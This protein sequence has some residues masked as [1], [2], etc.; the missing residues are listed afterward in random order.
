V[1][2]RTSVEAAVL[3]GLL[4]LPAPL[5]RRLVGPPLV[6]DGQT[7]SL[8]TQA[9]LWSQRLARLPGAETLPLPEGRRALLHQTEVVRGRQPIGE[10]R[11][12]T[13]AGMPARHYLPSSTVPGPGPMV[14][15]FHGG[16]FIFGDLDSHDAPCRV[17]AEQ[18]GVPVLAVDYGL[19]P[20]NP[21]PGPFD[22][23]ET[24]YR[25]ALDHAADLDL[26]PARL[27]VGGDSAG[28]NLAAWT[29]VVAARSRLPLAW[30]LLI[31]PVTQTTHDTLSYRLFNKD[32]FLTGEFMTLVNDTFLPE[33]AHREDER[34]NLLTSDLPTGL[35]PA[36][37]ITAGFDPLRDEGEAYADRLRD[38]GAEVVTRRF[39]DQIHGFINVTGLGGTSRRA[40]D[41]I[42]AQVRAT[43]R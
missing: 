32:L 40:L 20:E 39:A 6:L 11:E 23:A 16:G 18:S 19:A 41:E 24:A 17:I 7:L 35:W 2:F 15:F 14:L 1:T 12:L 33:P 5:L 28:G 31:Y 13:V 25:W 36:Y 30:Q 34:V 4:S 37:L 21:F 8:D 42:A 38:A 22:D 26:D 27:A 29:A 9:V 3:R 10:V 43:L